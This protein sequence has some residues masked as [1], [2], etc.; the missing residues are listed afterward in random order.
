MLPLVIAC[1]NA[2]TELPSI[3]ICGKRSV[4]SLSMMF[5]ASID[6]DISH[7][8]IIEAERLGPLFGRDVSPPMEQGQLF[9]KTRRDMV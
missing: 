7:A 1:V 3:D 5:I 8:E 4:T 2:K 6:I 9:E